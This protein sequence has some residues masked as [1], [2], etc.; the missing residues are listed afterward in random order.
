MIP[1]TYEQ[2]QQHNV[3][4]GEAIR[5]AMEADL[6][7]KGR[8]QSL[9]FQPFSHWNETAATFKRDLHRKKVRLKYC[10]CG[11][12]CKQFTLVIHNS[13]VVVT[14]KCSQYV[15]T[16]VIYERKVFIKLTTVSSV[17]RSRVSLILVVEEC[18]T[19][20]SVSSAFT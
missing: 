15:S 6:N 1:D 3:G 7:S 17:Q 4:R 12:S 18:F 10:L 20:K 13:S 19:G 2:Q 16:V 14:R 5:E 9:G 8:D 11:Q